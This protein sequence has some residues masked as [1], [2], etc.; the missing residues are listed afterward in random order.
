MKTAFIKHLEQFNSLAFFY[1]LLRNY[2]LLLFIAFILIQSASCKR[3]TT[4]EEGRKLLRAMDSEL[5]QISSKISKTE[6]FK[7]LVELGKIPNLPLPFKFIVPIDS[8][9]ETVSF[10]FDQHRGVYT[11]DKKT[12]KASLNRPSD[13]LIIHFPFQTSY[14]TIA[15]YILTE[16]DESET[17]FQMLFPV[18]MKAKLIAGNAEFLNIDYH[19]SIEHGFPSTAD[20]KMTFGY[21]RLEGRMKTRFGKKTSSVKV[22]LKL[23]EENKP[24]IQGDI[25][26]E[27]KFSTHNTLIFNN[28]RIS[29]FVYPLTINFKSGFDFSEIYPSSIIRDFNQATAFNITNNNRKI[30][31]IYLEETMKKDRII[32]MIRYSD[33][34]EDDLEEVMIFVNRILNIKFV[35]L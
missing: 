33:N 5:I 9:H 21:F 18:R 10:D 23:T 8:I 26:S 28:Q 3:S 29:F 7:G 24:I 14:D 31:D 22:D 27:I 20:I 1:R 32:L 2:N 11:I 16:Y 17:A 13:S 12:G 25:F 4:S 15:T 19:A 30:G 35:S 34:T 6:A